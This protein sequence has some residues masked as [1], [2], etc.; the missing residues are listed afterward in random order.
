MVVSQIGG[1]FLNMNSYSGAEEGLPL[2]LKTVSWFVA[3]VIP[4]YMELLK[5]KGDQDV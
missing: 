1:G 5:R 4:S 3:G 2:T